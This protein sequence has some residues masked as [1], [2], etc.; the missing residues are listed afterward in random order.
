MSQHGEELRGPHEEVELPQQ[1]TEQEEIRA[2]QELLQEEE[3]QNHELNLDPQEENRP[4]Q[5]NITFIKEDPQ[6]E[7]ELRGSAYHVAYISKRNLI[8]LRLNFEKSIVFVNIA[9]SC[10]EFRSEDTILSF[11]TSDVICAAKK[12][13]SSYLCCEILRSCC[14]TY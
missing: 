11:E 9:M 8:A 13:M 1:H 14:E 3:V 6:R 12:M 4:P 2:P 5:K 7:H 10:I